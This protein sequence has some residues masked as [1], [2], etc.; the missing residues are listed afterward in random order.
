MN[1]KEIEILKNALRSN[2]TVMWN[3]DEKTARIVQRISTHKEEDDNDSLC[4]IFWNGQ[5]IALYNCDL[6]EFAMVTRFI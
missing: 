5:Y 4:A 3:P 1:D 6:S 2:N